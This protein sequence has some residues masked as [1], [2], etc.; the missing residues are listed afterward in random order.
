[1]VNEKLVAASKSVYLN[2]ALISIKLAAGIITGSLGIIAEFVHSS[3]DLVAS[4]LAYVGIKKASQP[5]DAHHQYGHER[6]ENISSLLQSALITITSL[7]IIYEAYGRFIGGTHVVKESLLGLAVMT[8]ALISDVLI[9][10]YLHRKSKTT[11]SPALEADAYHFSTDVYSTVAVIIGLAGAYLGFHF[12][13]VIAAAFVALIMLYISGK[14][15]IRSVMVMIDH[16]PEQGTVDQIGSIISKYPGIK[17]YHSLRAR[18]AGSSILVDVS[19]HLEK[20]IS[21]TKAHLLSESLEK[22]IRKKIPNI[23]EVV[24]HIEPESAHDS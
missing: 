18:E 20:S 3:F 10:R 14:L 15:G 4:L 23:K 24:I 17:N 13:D 16:M 5:A 11:N 22:R 6:F 1:M 21:L 7:F 9:A 8:G 12:L 19:I 2:A